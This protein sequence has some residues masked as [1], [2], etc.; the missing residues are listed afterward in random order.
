MA[1]CKTVTV[2]KDNKQVD[3]NVEDLKDYLSRGYKEVGAETKVK[4]GVKA[5]K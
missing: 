4:R 1:T 2:I 3:I 5:K